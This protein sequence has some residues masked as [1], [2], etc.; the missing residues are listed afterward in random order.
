MVIITDN[1]LHQQTLQHRRR[2]HHS[3]SRSTPTFF[4][5]APTSDAAQLQAENPG[6]ITDIFYHYNSI[7]INT[8]RIVFVHHDLTARVT[9]YFYLHRSVLNILLAVTSST[10][11]RRTTSTP[12][13][14]RNFLCSSIRLWLAWLMVVPIFAR[15]VLATPTQAFVPDTLPSLTNSALRI[16]LIRLPPRLP[17]ALLLLLL[18]LLW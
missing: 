14:Y 5:S 13:I 3:W 1:H 16:E 17:Q 6:L 11:I 9:V 2:H 8:Y 4:S 7:A 12:I 18:Q 10:S 15:S